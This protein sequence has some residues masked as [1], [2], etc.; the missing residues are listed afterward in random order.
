MPLHGRSGALQTAARSDQTVSAVG[1]LGCHL[2]EADGRSVHDRAAASASAGPVTPLDCGRRCRPATFAGPHRSRCAETLLPVPSQTATR[3]RGCT[4]PASPSPRRRPTPPRPEARRRPPQEAWPR[5]CSEQRRQPSL[6]ILPTETGAWMAMSRSSS[7]IS[8]LHRPTGNV[9][10]LTSD[11]DA[12]ARS[13]RRPGCA[14]PPR[15]RPPEAG[16]N[17]SGWEAALI[18]KGL[19]RGTEFGTAE[20]GS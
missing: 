10:T 4:P 3:S 5:S 7:T 1:A 11:R 17:R 9:S 19:Y 20:V 15:T 16:R 18:E 6:A 2:E 14:R 8:S 13:R 12:A